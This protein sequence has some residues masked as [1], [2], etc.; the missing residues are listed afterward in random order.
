MNQAA[1]LP[2]PADVASNLALAV[3]RQLSRQPRPHCLSRFSRFGSIDSWITTRKLH[4]RWVK[5]HG[6]GK[7]NPDSKVDGLALPLKSNR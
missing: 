2:I 1:T 7:T 4:A 6:T 3:S 5:D